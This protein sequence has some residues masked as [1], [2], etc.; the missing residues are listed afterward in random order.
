MGGGRRATPEGA[1]YRLMVRAL[2]APDGANLDR[3][4]V[5]KGWPVPK[6]GEGAHLRRRSVRRVR[7]RR[8]RVVPN[9]SGRLRRPREPHSRQHNSRRHAQRVRARSWLLPA[10]SAR[11]ISYA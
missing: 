10:T 1:T 11:Y 6:A 4:Q 2:R 9:A 7:D 8:R 5:V 3:I